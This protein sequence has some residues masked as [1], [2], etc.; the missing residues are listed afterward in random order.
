MKINALFFVAT[1]ASCTQAMKLEYK[2]TSLGNQAAQN[3]DGFDAS[4]WLDDVYMYTN[5]YRGSSQWKPLGIHKVQL[6][7][8]EMES[9]EFCLDVFGNIDCEKIRTSSSTCAWKSHLSNYVCTTKWFD[10]NWG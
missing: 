5:R 9:F 10:L 4:F 3:K 1:L 8:A 7:N 2:A 6:K